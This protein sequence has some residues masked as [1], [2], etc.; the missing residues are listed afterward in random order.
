MTVRSIDEHLNNT[1]L[2]RIRTTFD[3][4][5]ENMGVDIEALQSGSLPYFHIPEDLIKPNIVKHAEGELAYGLDENG[6]EHIAVF[7][8]MGWAIFGRNGEFTLP[9]G[10]AEQDPLDVVAIDERYDYWYDL[11]SEYVRAVD[12]PDKIDDPFD[13]EINVEAGFGDADVDGEPIDPNDE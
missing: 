3:A 6:I 10:V 13:D 9:D 5:V 1:A 11:L 2:E 7:N 8:V 4:L 12:M